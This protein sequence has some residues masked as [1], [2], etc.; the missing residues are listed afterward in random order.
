MYSSL[1]GMGIIR[2]TLLVFPPGPGHPTDMGS[3]FESLNADI[4][5]KSKP[6]ES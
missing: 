3:S 6:Q 4:Q 2:K 1:R 5:T